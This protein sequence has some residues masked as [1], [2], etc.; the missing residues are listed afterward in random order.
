[1]NLVYRSNLSNVVFCVLLVALVLS[2]SIL[3]AR[4]VTPTYLPAVTPGQFAQY[5]VLKDSCQSSLSGLCQS[6]ETNLNDTTYA[7]NQVVGVSGTAVTLELISIYRNGTGAHV[8][9]IVDVATGTSNVTAFSLKPGDYF[10]L[11]G[12][13]QAQDQIWGTSTAPQFNT[14]SSEMVLGEMR[15]V[16]HLN[17]SMSGSSYGMAFSGFVVYDFDQSSG[18]VIDTVFSVSSKGNYATKLDF[19]I[20]MVDNNIWGTAH[21]PDF[22]LGA[23][24]TSVNVAENTSGNLTISISRLYG[25][26]ATVGLSATP[27]SNSISCSFS[28]YSLSMD[29]SDTSTLSCT[30]SPGAYT[31]VVNGDGGY[32][33]HSKSV[34]VT[35]TA[36]P[37]QPASILTMPLVYGGIV[38]AAVVAVVVAFLFLR[39]KPR[40]PVVAP[41][42]ASAL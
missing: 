6:F 34:N 27:S 26:S 5:K 35:V 36:A 1:M 16:N 30:G 19:T 22:D 40:A 13:L 4:A 12:S 38:V 21:L 14:T 20:G 23:N 10:V 3:S 33:M 18:F 28:T 8:G 24:P 41:G 31:V 7:A 39:R 9:A 17:V 2:P 42:D 15:T 29:S 37:T 11:A 32:S 25:F